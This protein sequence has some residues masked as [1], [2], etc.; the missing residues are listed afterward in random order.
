MTRRTNEQ[1]LSGLSTPTRYEICRFLASSADGET[2]FT[3]LVTQVVTEAVASGESRLADADHEHVAIS[4]HHVHL[5]KLEEA[6]VLTY[7]LESG[8]VRA[9]PVLDTAVDRLQ[10]EPCADGAFDVPISR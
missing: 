4:L 5:P 7:D 10:S 3:D 1:S 2:T 6:E 8:L 9:G